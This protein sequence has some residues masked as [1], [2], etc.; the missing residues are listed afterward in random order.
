MDIHTLDESSQVEA[1][2]PCPVALQ[3]VMQSCV[4]THILP[5]YST[6]LYFSVSLYSSCSII[7]SE[8]RMLD[9]MNSST[10]HSTQWRSDTHVSP[11]LVTVCNA[12]SPWGFRSRDVAI[13]E[14][15][16]D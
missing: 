10:Q 11:L 14:S 4:D 1:D 13:V 5:H 9:A 16:E 15:G 3:A 2:A 7:P 12:L 6:I 8:S